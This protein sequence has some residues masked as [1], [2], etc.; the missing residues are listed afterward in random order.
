[1]QTPVLFWEPLG[2]AGLSEKKANIQNN[3]TK[4]KKKKKT[5]SVPNG[6]HT[7][8][9]LTATK[10][11]HSQ[12]PKEVHQDESNQGGKGLLQ[13]KPQNL[14][15]PACVAQALYTKPAHQQLFFL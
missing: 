1:M 9:E 12:E 15:C 7:K 2:L 10:A 3:S 4:K 5:F 11:W 8:K 6:K 13:C 14:G